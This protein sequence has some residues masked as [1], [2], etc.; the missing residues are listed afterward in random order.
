MRKN[1]WFT[2]HKIKMKKWYLVFV[3]AVL[4]IVWIGSLTG[5][6]FVQ[7]EQ[8]KYEPAIC[9]VQTWDFVDSKGFDAKVVVN[10]HFKQNTFINQT[11]VIGCPF[12]YKAEIIRSNCAFY[13]PN[14]SFHCFWKQDG[15]VDEEPSTGAEV[16]ASVF[17][18]LSSGGIII[19]FTCIWME[20]R[21]R[22]KS[23]DP[24]FSHHSDDESVSGLSA[25]SDTSTE[26]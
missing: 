9:T 3:A 5:Y 24:M 2:L 25:F 23:A 14:Y 18:I 12:P 11:S 13:I 10:V 17:L 15:W 21:Y 8:K 22:S 4:F 20:R 19:F 16:V 26:P 1:F 7:K 6:L